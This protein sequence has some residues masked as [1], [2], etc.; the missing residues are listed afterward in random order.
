MTIFTGCRSN[1][2]GGPGSVRTVDGRTIPDDIKWK[3]LGDAQRVRRDSFARAGLDPALADKY[4]PSIV[5][6]GMDYKSGSGGPVKNTQYGPVH[7]TNNI[8]PGQTKGYTVQLADDNFNWVEWVLS[9]EDG[10][11]TLVQG[12]LRYPTGN[13]G[14]T[15][16]PDESPGHPQ[17]IIRPDGK[18]LDMGYVINGRWPSRTWQWLKQNLNPLNWGNADPEILNCTINHNH[19]EHESN[20]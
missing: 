8:R 11:H 20:D 6:L 9:H 7:G 16:G 5:F 17:Y 10:G 3:A 15:F 4:S 19:E 2:G 1:D 14:Y 18:K 12:E 13:H